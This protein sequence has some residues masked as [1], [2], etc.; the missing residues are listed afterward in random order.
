MQLTNGV[1]RL[2]TVSYAEWRATM[3]AALVVQRVWAVVRDGMDEDEDNEELMTKNETAMALLML[4][5]DAV[6]RPTIEAAA[7]AK[8][9]WDALHHMHLS[10]GESRQQ[11]LRTELATLRKTSRESMLAYL[12]RALAMK[13]E[14]LALEADVPRA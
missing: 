4:H 1:P 14:L 2:G 9:A 8:D 6:Y 12:S 5:V 13:T 3:R 10:Q 7:S 11:Q